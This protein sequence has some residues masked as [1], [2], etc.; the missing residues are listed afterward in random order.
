MDYYP[1]KINRLSHKKKR[2]NFVKSTEADINEYV[3]R[4]KV[5]YDQVIRKVSKQ[6]W[7]KRGWCT[8]SKCCHV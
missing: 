5:E 4:V 3:M 7:T 1:V 2:R 8:R 6:K